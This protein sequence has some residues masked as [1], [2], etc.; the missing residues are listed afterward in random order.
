MTLGKQTLVIIDLSG[1]HWTS[2]IMSFG[3]LKLLSQTILKML[4]LSCNFWDCL[5]I[6]F[7]RSCLSNLLFLSLM[8]YLK[9]KVGCRWLC[10]FGFFFR[11]FAGQFS[12]HLLNILW[13]QGSDWPRFGFLALVE[14]VACWTWY[15]WFKHFFLG[16]GQLRA[17]IQHLQHLLPIT[18]KHQYSERITLHSIAALMATVPRSELLCKNWR[19]HWLKGHHGGLE[20]VDCCSDSVLF[21]SRH[22]F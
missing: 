10:G 15:Y 18:G 2:F 21:G 14:I 6:C 9:M 13:I 8:G 11:R 7:V 4:N 20:L 1:L 12:W 3:F 17:Q 16:L 5:R 19:W 22:S